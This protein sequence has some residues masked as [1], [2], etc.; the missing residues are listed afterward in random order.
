MKSQGKPW[1]VILYD[2]L[3]YGCESDSRCACCAHAQA[4]NYH[5]KGLDITDIR[6]VLEEHRVQ[7]AFVDGQGWSTSVIKE[8]VYIF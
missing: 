8:Y 3:E 1:C 6:H 4:L 7:E 5:W 2:D